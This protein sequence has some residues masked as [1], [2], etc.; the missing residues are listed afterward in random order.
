MKFPDVYDGRNDL[1]HFDNWIS[2]VS[3][4]ADVMKIRETTMIKMLH[5]CLSGEAQTFHKTYVKGRAEQWRFDTYFAALFEYCFPKDIMRKLRMKWNVITQ[6]KRRVRSYAREIELLSARFPEMNERTVVIKFWEGLNSELREIM[7]FGGVDPEI[8]AYGD[9][10][11]RADDAER[12]RDQRHLERSIKPEGAKQA[13]KREWGRFK[14]N[15]NRNYNSRTGGSSNGRYVDREEKSISNRS[16]RIRANAVSPPNDKT[17]RQRPEIQRQNKKHTPNPKM[18]VLRAEGRCFNCHEI[19]HEKRN[20]HKLNSM[21]PPKPKIA[22]SSMRVSKLDRI[23][24][25]EGSDVY[26]ARISIE[27]TDPIEQELKEFDELEF[28]VH[29]MCEEAW[30]EDPLWYDE[31]T[32]PDCRWSV[33]A[34][35]E[36]IEIWDF[37]NGGSRSF[38]TN[39][40][41]NPEFDFTAIF[42]KPEPNRTPKSVREGGFPNLEDY[43]ANKWPASNWIRARL[44]GQLDFVDEE[45]TPQNNKCRISVEPILSGYSARLDKTDVFY[46]ISHDEVLSEHFSPAQIIDQMITARNL[47]FNKRGDK[48]KDKRL[49]INEELLVQLGMTSVQKGKKS[50]HKKNNKETEG[51]STVERTALRVKDRT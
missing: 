31:E 4:Y 13:P 44:N 14:N 42:S 2:S 33:Y 11:R 28:R 23:A 1:E 50:G 45:G 30:G 8:T 41:V 25:R 29:K 24:N 9:L 20:C 35:N 6:G 3:N 38:P 26:S 17:Q 5:G 34:D 19:G 18:D 21:K 7:A 47:P 46:N 22:T 39:E 12:A 40:L 32:R 36:I 10:V 43:D 48:F 49:K 27:I 51:V 15:N 37:E 16:D